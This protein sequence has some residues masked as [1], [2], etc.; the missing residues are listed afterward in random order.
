MVPHRGGL[1]DNAAAD[2]D[3]VARAQQ[4]PPPAVLGFV[5]NEYGLIPSLAE[6]RSILSWM[7]ER[8]VAEAP[9]PAPWTV[10]ALALQ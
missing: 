5:L 2:P 7:L 6:A 1:G 10:V 8:P 9:E 3:V 4:R